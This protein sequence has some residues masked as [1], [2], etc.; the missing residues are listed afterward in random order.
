MSNLGEASG[1]NWRFGS[2][3]FP[4]TSRIGAWRDAVNRIGLTS[5]LSDVEVGLT[6][7]IACQ[8][9]PLG[10]LFA[11]MASGAQQFVRRPSRSDD[12]I[13]IVKH[14]D[15]AATLKDGIKTTS[16]SSG[17][18]VVACG[19]GGFTLDFSTSFRQLVVRVP[20]VVINTR[21]LSL[22]SSKVVH[23][24]GRKGF[25]LVFSQMLDAVMRTIEMLD[26]SELRSIDIA[27]LSCSNLSPSKKP[28]SLSRPG[29]SHRC[30]ADLR[31]AAP[32]TVSS[33]SAAGYLA[34]RFLPPPVDLTADFLNFGAGGGFIASSS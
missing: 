29:T 22:Q 12:G 28:K 31:S 23:L 20:R 27:N 32:R 18:I 4:D 6:G 34:F 24:S 15:G 7:T 30:T 3:A 5:T 11:Q 17:D 25:G 2:E 26:S 1:G 33:C 21:L 16:L 19:G 8:T 10:V 13:L 9:S 14:V